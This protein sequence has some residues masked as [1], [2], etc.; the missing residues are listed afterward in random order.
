MSPPWRRP[1]ERHA[2]LQKGGG[3]GGRARRRHGYCGH[4]HHGHGPGEDCPHA[5]AHH[6]R[7][8]FWRVYLHGFFLLFVAAASVAILGWALG[9]RRGGAMDH[10]GHFHAQLRE[11]GRALLEDRPKLEVLLHR[12]GEQANANVTV[13]RADGAVLGTNVDPPL[14]VDASLVDT[15]GGQPLYVG[16]PRWAVVLPVQ[17]DGALVGYAVAEWRGP[18]PR[19]LARGATYFFGVVAALALASVPLVRTIISPIERLRQAVR[20]FGEGDLTVRSGIRRRDEVGELAQAFDEMAATLEQQ[21]KSERE[22]LANVSHELRTPLSRIR[23]ALELGAEG[24][25]HKAQRYLKEIGGDLAEL[26]RLVEDVLTAARLDA[27]DRSG[28]PLPMHPAPVPAED[29]LNAAAAR[30][31]EL[32]PERVLEEVVTQ[33]LPMLR[34]DPVLL[35]RALDNLLDNARKYS[36]HGTK[37]TL[38]A[39]R[40]GGGALRVE[41]TDMGI[42]MSEADLGAIFTPFFRTDRSRARG[43]GGVGLGLVLARR[44]IEAH[45]GSLTARSAPGA[46]T[47]FTLLVPAA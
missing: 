16:Q 10:A 24:D 44:I 15:L 14:E 7:R 8:L 25:A 21:V 37:V 41:V 36:D 30:F 45:G 26:E 43:T 23:V 11:G 17:E 34:A 22:L 13:R 46:G 20:A 2:H 27:R 19:Q 18:G 28:E 9:G 12:A 31:R 42:G 40:E 33:P 4:P 35:R 32:F 6:P 5:H 38:R 47:T 29:V 1:H 3:A 39:R